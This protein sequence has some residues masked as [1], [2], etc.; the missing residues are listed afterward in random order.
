VRFIVVTFGSEGDTRPIVALGRGLVDAGHD[1]RLFLEQS[2]VGSARLHAIPAEALAGDM[3]ST[4]PMSN[5]S[6]ELRARD[7]LKAVKDGLRVVRDNTDAWMRTITE[8]ARGSDAI[9]F[10]GLASPM[11]EVIARR[12]CKPA[13]NLCLQPTSPTREF[14]SS[15]FPSV[16]L[17]G[18]LNLLSY[19]ASPSALMRRLYGKAAKAAE[20]EVFGKGGGGAAVEFP[21]LYGFS[22]HLVARPKDWPANHQI[23]G[24]WPL[25]RTNWQ[26][27]NDLQAF[28]SAGEPPIYVGFGA[29]SSFIRPKR[30]AEI[31]AAIA[32]R[33][34]LFYPGWSQ[35]T[36][37]M[38]PVNCF[39]VGD[40]PHSWLFPRTSIII[41]HGGAGTTHAAALAGVPSI[42]L[43]FGADQFFW[44]GRLAAVGIAPKYVRGTK[45]E[46]RELANMIDFARQDEVRE[47]ARTFGTLMCE[48]HGVACAVKAIEGLLAGA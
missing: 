5:P 41:H 33:R 39:V 36:S 22:P 13:I 2:T 34:A 18:W 25:P 26:P 29:A 6:Q 14:A 4:L 43:P 32:G 10:G 37:A 45:I 16:K 20:E 38:L 35:I 31:V 1:V 46:A 9:L 42:A 19:R 8:H 28:L 48:E 15:I 21:I 11:M 23:C 17:P 47:R 44:A 27:P 40:T 7:V 3:K 24:Y 12:L 30:L